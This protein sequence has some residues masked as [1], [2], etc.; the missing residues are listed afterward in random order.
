M[1]TTQQ[2]LDDRYGRVRRRGRVR[3]FWI[4]VIAIAVGGFGY[5]A[6]STVA[7]AMVTV[8]P[9]DLGYEVQDESTVSVSFQFSAP[10]ERDVACAVSAL[11]EEFGTVGWKIFEY[12]PGD[13]RTQRHTEE[14]PTVAEATTGLV[15]SCWVI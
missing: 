13:G 9:A 4:A 11:D 10:D 8:D 15:N 7:T 3:A 14:V 6:W 5:L 12:G 1:T 2:M